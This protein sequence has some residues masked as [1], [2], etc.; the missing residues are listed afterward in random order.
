MISVLGKVLREFSNAITPQQNRVAERR[1]R[2]LIE[3]IRTMLVDA[4]LP[5]TFWAE[6][7]NTACYVQ[8]RVLVTKPFNKTPYELFNGRLERITKKRTKNK[9]KTKKPG[10]GME[11]T[12]KDKAKSKPKSQS[13]QPRGKKSK[14]YKFR[15]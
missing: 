14:K 11:N 12:V 6:A 3:A 13:S 15:D 9:A 2:T 4:K 1:N 10:L 8:N 7:V 5:V